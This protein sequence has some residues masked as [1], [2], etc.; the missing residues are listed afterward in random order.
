MRCLGVD[1]VCDVALM[2][3][4]VTALH[5]SGYFKGHLGISIH[6]CHNKIGCFLERP[7]LISCG[8]CGDHNRLFVTV[9]QTTSICDHGK[10]GILGQSIMV[11]WPL[12]EQ[13]ISTARWQMRNRKFNLSKHKERL[14]FSFLQTRFLAIVY[15]DDWVVLI[16]MTSAEHLSQ[17]K[18]SIIS[19][20]Q[21]G[22]KLNHKR[23]HPTVN[24]HWKI[25]LKNS[26]SII[27][28]MKIWIWK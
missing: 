15:S 24:N 11:S 27:N 23:K 4:I 18:A 14:S 21:Y 6:F 10:I 26:H 12:S 3:R 17:A 19:D 25:V 9:I 20:N 1:Q 16:I 13:S 8:F 2:W 22:C 28:N 7:A 5:T